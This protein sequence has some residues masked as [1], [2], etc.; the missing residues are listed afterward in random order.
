M[1]KIITGEQEK[2]LR[3]VRDFLKSEKDK[4]EA[5]FSS[6]VKPSGTGGHIIVPSKYVGHK[7]K[8][9]IYKKEEESKK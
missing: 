4:T 6:E 9:K 1:I 7:A 5:E 8:V 3:E 2:I